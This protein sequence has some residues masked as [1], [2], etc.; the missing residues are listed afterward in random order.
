MPALYPEDTLEKHIA[1][2]QTAILQLNGFEVAAKR[3]NSGP[4][5]ITVTQGDDTVFHAAKGGL[6]DRAFDSDDKRGYFLE[7][8]DIQ[9]QVLFDESFRRIHASPETTPMVGSFTV[10]NQVTFNGGVGTFGYVPTPNASIGETTG[11]SFT[12]SAP[13]YEVIE[14]SDEV[15]TKHLYRLR[16]VKGNKYSDYHD[17]SNSGWGEYGKLYELPDRAYSGFKPACVGGWEC[18]TPDQVADVFIVRLL[19][20]ARLRMVEKTWNF[21]FVD[22]NLDFAD[23]TYSNDFECSISQLLQ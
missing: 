13:D 22:F 15:T 5:Y 17:L 20:S 21:G 8:F 6:H 11:T 12:V 1:G 4:L 9:T 2:G 3:R 19:M 10:S 18:R 23:V 7:S 14:S 16:A